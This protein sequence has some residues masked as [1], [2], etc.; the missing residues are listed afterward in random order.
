MFAAALATALFA[1]PLVFAT[2][3]P[4]ASTCPG[5]TSWDGGLYG[6]NGQ[7]QLS[8][9][10]PIAPGQ[11]VRVAVVNLATC[12]ESVTSPQLMQVA[13]TVFNS[14]TYDFTT[15]SSAGTAVTIVGATPDGGTNLEGAVQ[16]NFAGASYAEY[17]AVSAKTALKW[18][19][20]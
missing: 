1:L 4:R 2:P 17:E 3:V 6:P 16:A 7:T 20:V 12:A 5:T 13:V 11:Q 10:F 19:V 15:V 9:S 18:S 14:D 8:G